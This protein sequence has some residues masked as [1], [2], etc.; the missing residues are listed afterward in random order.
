MPGHAGGP[1][2]TARNARNP[3]TETIRGLLLRQPSGIP[4]GTA[5]AWCAGIL[6]VSVA[7]SAWLFRGRTG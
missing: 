6:A 5:L 4:T 2:Q 3:V 7:V 1:G